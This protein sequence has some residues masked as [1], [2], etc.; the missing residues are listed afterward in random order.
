MK[1]QTKYRI[2]MSL[3]TISVFAFFFTLTSMH[4]PTRITHLSLQSVTTESFLD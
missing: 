1:R 3:V 2:Y 4:Q